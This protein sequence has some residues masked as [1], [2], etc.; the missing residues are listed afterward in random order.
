MLLIKITGI[1]IILLNFAGLVYLL[2]IWFRNTTSHY[3][4]NLSKIKTKPQKIINS[5][6]NNIIEESFIREKD[7]M[8][9]DLDLSD[10]DDLNLDDF[11]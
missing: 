3:N 9:D 5:A 4:K 8:L 11:D 10:F 6:D 7:D 1:I 2:L